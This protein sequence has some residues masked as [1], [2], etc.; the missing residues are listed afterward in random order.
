MLL[1]VLGAYLCGSL[2]KKLVSEYLAQARTD[3][4][5]AGDKALTDREQQVV[6]LLADGKTGKE[7]A[8]EL[9]I[10]V[11]TVERHR[12]NIMAKLGFQTRAEVVKYALHKGLINGDL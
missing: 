10:S 9:E 12:Q 3:E 8:R 5:A 7:I 4:Q 2:S 11:H 6:R 1:G